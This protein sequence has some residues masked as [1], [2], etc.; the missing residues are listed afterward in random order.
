MVNLPKIIGISGN[1]TV[2]KDLFYKLLSRRL[3]DTQVKRFAFAD[4]LKEE[5]APMILSEY[6]FNINKCSKEQ[7]E[8]IRPFLVNYGKKK[9]DETNGRYWIDILDN[10][11]KHFHGQN[12]EAVACI[13]D[14]RY[15]VYEDDEV[16]WIKEEN[17]GILVH[18]Q[19]F[20]LVSGKQIFIP[21]ANNDEAENEPKLIKKANYKIIWPD[22]LGNED[23]INLNNNYHIL[24]KGLNDY[25]EEFVKWL[26]R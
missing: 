4:A 8:L 3:I 25:I 11:V 10:Q 2:G 7:K 23:Y 16:S 13:T 19:K 6:G 17:D 21:P 14:C 9:R 12:Q 26:K 5:V 15:D 20:T 1:A 22:L 18:I 24:V